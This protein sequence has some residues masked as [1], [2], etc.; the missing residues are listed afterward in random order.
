MIYSRLKIGS[1]FV[2]VGGSFLS[3][4]N[5][6]IIMEFEVPTN[7]L[8]LSMT[9]RNGYKFDADIDWGDG[10]TEHIYQTGTNNSISHS[11]IDAGTKTITIHGKWEALKFGYS[12]NKIRKVLSFGH[13]KKTKLKYINFAESMLNELPSSNPN[14]SFKYIDDASESFGYYDKGFAGTKL[15]HVPVDL[16]NGC[17]LLTSIGQAFQDC[18]NLVSV[19]PTAFKGLI[20]ITN[21]FGVFSN[22]SLSSIPDDLFKYNTKLENVSYLFNKCENL[23]TLPSTLFSN[24]I[25]ISN[26]ESTFYGCGDITSSTPEFWD[27]QLWPNVVSH[28]SC[29]MNSINIT[30]FNDIPSDWK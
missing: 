1:K 10:T 23:L 19:D 25:L 28:S 27:N 16:F 24:N 14:S 29:F 12:D 11:Y 7:D 6:K 17:T 30:N 8:N 22:S 26:F 9:L 5:P 18:S 3:T 4:V 15:T 2:G 13:P 20:N 21:M